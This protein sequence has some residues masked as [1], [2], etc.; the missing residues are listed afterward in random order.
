MIWGVGSMSI[1]KQSASPYMGSIGRERISQK[2]FLTTLQYYDLLARSRAVQVENSKNQKETEEKAK[3]EPFSFDQLRAL[4]WQAIVL[5]REAKHQG[6]RV[7]D[8]Q[9]REEVE[10]LFSAAG[11][12]NETLY[13]NWLRT[14]FRGRARDFE[15]AIRKHLAVQKIRQK[16]LEGVPETERESHWLKWLEPILSQTRIRDYTTQKPESSE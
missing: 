11:G 4:T 1:S 12:F 8:D 13:Q 10:K 5:S 16:V 6:I 15:E 2:E 7:S 9:V 3:A 14:N